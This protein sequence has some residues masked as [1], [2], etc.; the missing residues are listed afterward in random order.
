VSFGF[1]SAFFFVAPDFAET[2]FKSF[3]RTA[4]FST[5]FFFVFSSIATT[6]IARLGNRRNDCN[7]LLNPVNWKT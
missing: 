5:R 1:L 4:R 2:P 7:P 3:F 6:L